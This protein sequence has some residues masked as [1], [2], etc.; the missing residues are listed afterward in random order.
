MAAALAM[1]LSVTWNHS[2]AGSPWRLLSGQRLTGARPQIWTGAVR[3][4]RGHPIT[5][6][7]PDVFYT[8][9]P[10]VMTYAFFVAE[11]PVLAGDSVSLRLPGS[12]HNEPLA[13]ASGLGVVGLGFYVWALVAAARAGH[14]SA[15]F[16][17]AIAMWCVHLV[18]PGSVATSMTFWLLL[19]AAAGPGPGAKAPAWRPGAGRLTV[20][21][22]L[23]A[24]VMV[25]ALLTTLRACVAQAH[26]REAGWLVFSGRPAALSDHLTR[27]DAYAARVHPRY[28]ADDAAQ[29]R[30]LGDNTRATALLGLARAGNPENMFYDSALADLLLERGKRQHDPAAIAESGRILAADLARAPAALSLYADLAEVAD[31]QGRPR[32]AARLRAER[33]RLDPLNLFKVRPVPAGGVPPR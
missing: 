32:E 29:W 9:F 2:H 12:P 4:L 3:L 15:L 8:R 19:V 23:V 6:V 22:G 16:L 1:L 17:A 27:W 20:I 11:P 18:N 26:R 14:R 7:G 24:I 13:I 10:S 30:Q 28:A 21:G 31:A 5:G 33:Q 25:V